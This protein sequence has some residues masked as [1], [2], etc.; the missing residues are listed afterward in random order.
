MALTGHYLITGAASGIGAATAKKIAGPNCT[1]VLQ[2]KSNVAGLEEIAEHCRA[3]SAHVIV[4]QSDLTQRDETQRLIDICLANCPSLN[5]VVSTAGYPDWGNFE[6]LDEEQLMQSMLLMQ[7]ST[8]M[9]LKYLNT[10]LQNTKGSFIGI[11]TFLAHKMQVGNSITPASSSAKAGLEALIKS[12]AVQYAASGIRANAIVPGYIK[13]DGAN[14]KP[15]N[16][17]ALAQINARI[18]AGRL[19]LP[20][21]VAS[22][23]QFLLSSQSRYITGQLIHIDGGLLLK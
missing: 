15:P 5:G 1:L 19:G 23:A 7:Q 14:H 20:E 21:E 6:Q 12:Y 10:S 11:S 18:P 16:P 17:D 2:T 9:L 22:L 3:K 8:F 4:N 13:K